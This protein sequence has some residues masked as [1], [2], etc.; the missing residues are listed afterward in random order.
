MKKLCLIFLT[1]SLSITIGA[2]SFDAYIAAGP[3]FSQVDGDRVG[4]YDKLGY[5]AGV[6]VS[7]PID[8]YWS[9]IMEL[10]YIQKGTGS[11]NESD[12]AT[13]RTVLHY[14]HLPILIDYKLTDK[15][16]IETGLSLGALVGHGFYEDGYKSSTSFDDFRT[17]DLDWLAGATYHA[18]ERI[19]VNLRFAYSLTSITN[20]P[21]DVKDTSYL[22]QSIYGK[23]NRSLSLCCL[24]FF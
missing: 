8:L 18:S 23:Y 6:G 7:Y 22:F 21:D 15:F 13:Y 3:V 20:T 16:S 1:C 17:F 24:Y 4:G 14:L 19:K 9:A 11:Y 5:T 2:Q 10:G 12:N